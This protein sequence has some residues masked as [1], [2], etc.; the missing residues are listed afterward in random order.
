MK[1]ILNFFLPNRDFNTPLNSVSNTYM[2]KYMQLNYLM[3][4][5]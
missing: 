4:K 5:T 1:Y 3:Y 2:N